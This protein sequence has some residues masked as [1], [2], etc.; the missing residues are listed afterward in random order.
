V[1]VDTFRANRIETLK[2]FDAVLERYC[3]GSETEIQAVKRKTDE[4]FHFWLERKVKAA[5]EAA[6]QQ[7]KQ[8]TKRVGH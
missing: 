6:A 4:E 2:N 8:Q 3:N 7:R 1:E 5:K